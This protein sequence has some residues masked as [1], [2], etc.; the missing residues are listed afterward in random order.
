MVM[1]ATAE[2]SFIQGIS[3]RAAR[4]TG[5]SKGNTPPESPMTPLKKPTEPMAK[6]HA[7]SGRAMAR[8][9]FQDSSGTNLRKY[10]PRRR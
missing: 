3:Q 5:P 7:N 1:R 8:V 10:R 4:P 6:P 9:F 2:P